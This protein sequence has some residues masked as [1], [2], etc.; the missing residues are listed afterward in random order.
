MLSFLLSQRFH[1]AEDSLS[2]T[3]GGSHSASLYPSHSVPDTCLL[4]TLTAIPLRG[5][6]R[7]S[8]L[9]FYV[10]MGEVHNLGACTSEKREDRTLSTGSLAA[11]YAQATRQHVTLSQVSHR[12]ELRVFQGIDLGMINIE[13]LRTHRHSRAAITA[14]PD[15]LPYQTSGYRVRLHGDQDARAWEVWQSIINIAR[16]HALDY[17]SSQRLVYW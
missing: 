7:C 17:Q 2:T 13:T 6:P 10:R 12:V 16:L 15:I 3:A 9:E 5:R 1:G 11:L 8:E 14:D 4:S